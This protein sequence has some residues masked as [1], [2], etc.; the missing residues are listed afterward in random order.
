MRAAARA[1]FV[2]FSSPLEGV[3]GWMYLDVLGYVTCGMGDLVDSV[4]AA[5]ALPWRRV[6]GSLAG[7]DEV[8]AAWHAVDACRTAPKGVKQPS[9]LATKYGGAFAGVT[10]LRLDQAGIDAAVAK[11]LAANEILLRYYFP[12]FDQI[13][14]DGQLELHSMCWA[15]GGGFAAKFPRFRAAVSAG[16]YAD[17][18]PESVFQGAGIERRIEQDELLL[19]NAQ[20]VIDR[21]LDPDVLYWPTDLAPQ[22]PLFPTAST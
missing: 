13:P 4:A 19:R 21:G 9:G 14:A 22:L 3:L 10:T 18:A 5:Q 17:A 11:Q 16:R 1:A 6:D 15:M 2:R 12:T 20:A 7:P 8:A